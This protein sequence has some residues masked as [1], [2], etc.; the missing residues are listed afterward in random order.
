[1]SPRALA[2]TR[3]N[4]RRRWC[5]AALVT[6]GI[7]AG[8][9]YSPPSA[10]AAIAL[11]IDLM[12]QDGLGLV[13]M[14]DP[15]WSDL[16]ITPTKTPIGNCGCWR[17]SIAT[18]FSFESGFPA[19]SLP[20]FPMALDLTRTS[21]STCRSRR[22]TST[23][24]R[25]KTTGTIR[26]TTA[27]K[28]G[29]SIKPDAFEHAANPILDAVTGEPLTPTGLTWSTVNGFG[30]EVRARVD[31]SLTVAGPWLSAPYATR[32]GRRFVQDGQ[33]HADDRRLP[34][35]P[36]GAGEYLVLDP[37]G[38]GATGPQA[39]SF[40]FDG[41]DEPGVW[42]ATVK[43]CD[44]SNRLRGEQP[45]F[46]L[47]DDPEP[48]ELVVTDP[49]GRRMGVDPRTGVSHNEQPTGSYERTNGWPTRWGSSA[50]RRPEA[51]LDAQPDR[52]RLRGRG[53]R[54]GDR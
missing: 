3:S 36:D 20:R 15:R 31:Q 41:Y 6:A 51:L 17:A 52:R 5:L 35:G 29:T 27:G 28:C 18:I 43:T 1:M 12:R 49:V 8:L 16:A 44:S 10:D 47:F 24:S 22:R 26:K 42:A 53:D 19:G 7:A 25:A 30:P 45:W 37:S 54:H 50:R 40:V 14:N 21:G 4:R 13:A 23:R 33:P 11:P 38:Y 46:G 34:A 9:W 39:E 32:A 48:I 2:P